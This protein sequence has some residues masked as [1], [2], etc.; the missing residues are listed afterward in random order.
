VRVE[1]LRENVFQ[2]TATAPELSAL[3]AGARMALDVMRSGPDP[4]AAAIKMLEGVLGDFDR[5]RQRLVQPPA[6]DDRP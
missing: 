1:R 4:P 6:P 3:V 5:G 2:V